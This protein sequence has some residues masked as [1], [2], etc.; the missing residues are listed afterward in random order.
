MIGRKDLEDLTR[1]LA[2]LTNSHPIGEI[3]V[4]ETDL[5]GPLVQIIDH[6]VLP[7]TE[8]K[9][10]SS[11]ERLTLTLAVVYQVVGDL[12]LG[13]Q[14][15]TKIFPQ[16]YEHGIRGVRLRKYPVKYHRATGAQK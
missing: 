7:T 3:G 1:A 9:T 8:A 13:R 6:G 11:P 15:S 16:L 4:L 12:P 2:D 14:S 10:S 5:D